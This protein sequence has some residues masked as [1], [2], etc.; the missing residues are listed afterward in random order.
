[1]NARN[2]NRPTVN[3]NLISIKQHMPSSTMDIFV[4]FSLTTFTVTTAVAFQCM[5]HSYSVKNDFMFKVSLQFILIYCFVLTALL[6][7]LVHL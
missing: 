5:V 3:V 6:G 4:L 1:M 2:K 7:G